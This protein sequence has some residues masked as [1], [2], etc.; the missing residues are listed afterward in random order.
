[1]KNEKGKRVYIEIQK[2]FNLSREHPLKIKK[3]KV[4]QSVKL[5]GFLLIYFQEE[6]SFALISFKDE[7]ST[8][9]EN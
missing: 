6:T 5:D 2:M 8:V 9:D 7:F 3:H 1:L 4:V